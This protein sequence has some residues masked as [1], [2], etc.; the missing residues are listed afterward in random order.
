MRKKGEA[1]GLVLC[2][3]LKRFSHSLLSQ[4]KPEQSY[5]DSIVHRGGDLRFFTRPAHYGFRIA[6]SSPRLEEITLSDDVR[7]IRCF[8]DPSHPVN[9]LVETDVAAAGRYAAF[10]VF[11]ELRLCM[12]L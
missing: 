5:F 3:F 8:R 7:I 9:E 1:P 12:I 6:I 4:R 11:D 2:C 10:G